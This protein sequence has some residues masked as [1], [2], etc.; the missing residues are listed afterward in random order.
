MSAAGGEALNVEDVFSTYL[1]PG[2]SSTQTITNGIDLSGEGGLVWVKGRSGTSGS[3]A[4][5]GDIAHNLFDSSAPQRPMNSALF[6]TRTNF[7]AA[8]VNFTST[9]FTVGY[10]GYNDLNYPTIPYVSWS[11]RK[12]PKF[13]DVVTW[14]GDGS[15]NAGGSRLISHGLGSV[16]GFIIVKRTSSVHSWYCYHRELGATKAITLNS[17]GASITSANWW[18][19]V[20]PTSTNFS[21]NFNFN[22][23]NETYVAYVFAH[24]DGDGGFGP[25][26]DADIIKCGS[27]NGNGSATDG[28][29]IDLGFEPQWVMVKKA[30]LSGSWYMFD[31]MRGMTAGG[32]DDI[33][34]QANSADAEDGSQDY[35]GVLPNGFQAN[36]SGGHTNASNGTYIYMAI[37]RGPMAVPESATDVF[38]LDDVTAAGGTDV[39]TNFPVDTQLQFYLGSTYKLSYIHDRLRGVSTNSSSEGR[40]LEPNN[41][42]TESNVGYARQWGSTGFQVPSGLSNFRTV[43]YNWKRA[44]GFFDVV[45]YTGNNTTQTVSHNLGVTP[46]LIIVKSRSTTGF[47]RTLSTSLSQ[48][49]NLNTTGAFTGAFVETVFG[50]NTVYVAPTETQFTLG[51]DDSVNNG[52]VTYI[53]YLFASLPGI[54]KV[55]SYVGTGSSGNNVDCG[56]SSGARFVLIRRVNG[57]EWMVFDTARGITSA[58]NDPML[59]LNSTAAESS[60]SNRDLDPLNSGFTVNGADT[61]MNKSGDTYIFYAIA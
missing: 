55:G 56:F 16:P 25:D 43:Y 48:Y 52:A 20:E 29:E 5:G 6:N 38:A 54:S 31:S 35:I 11:F 46:E 49:T 42:N 36:G 60:N 19:N 50:N 4:W 33:Y 15:T 8:G 30:N 22:G 45:A 61:G 12:A 14:T 32:S 51:S 41:V 40:D 59:A 39:T 58:T 17:T 23:N 21:V 24:N 7:G 57:D 9:G 53:A 18:Y 47:W 13:F 27:Y 26:G 34:L 44:P 37:R 28:P 3:S 1:Y 10:N 2:T